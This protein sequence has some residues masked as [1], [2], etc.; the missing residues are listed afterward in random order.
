LF[1]ERPPFPSNETEA[2]NRSGFQTLFENNDALRPQNKEVFER[3]KA[4]EAA[5]AMQYMDG[6]DAV[7]GARR[8]KESM[9]GWL[10]AKV[11]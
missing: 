7:E 9:L 1:E 4:N 3:F 6:E 8:L 5:V 11:S 10:K 2:L